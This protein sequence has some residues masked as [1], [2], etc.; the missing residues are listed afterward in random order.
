MADRSARQVRCAIY[1]RKSVARDLDGEQNSL[2]VQRDICSAYVRTQRHRAWTEMP[3]RYDD[4][5]Y[6]GGSLI[7]PALQQLIADV[8]E[9]L[10]DVIVIYKLD[11]LTRSLA[12]FIRLI[13]VF[14]ANGVTFVSVT[15]SF[16]TQDTM[17]RL[18]LNVLL[19]FAQFEREMIADRVRDKM[20]Q[21]KRAGRWT[22]GAPPYGYD[23]IDKR[24]VVNEVEA[25]QVR[26][27]F[28][29]YL[30][31]ESA[32]ALTEELRAGGL[33]A[34]SWVT[35]QGT[36]CGGGIATRG[37]IYG[38]LGSPV[39]I[40]EFHLRGEVFAGQHEPIVERAL[41][42]RVQAVREVR[43]LKRPPRRPYENLLL[44][45]AFDDVGRRMR[46]ETMKPEYGYRYYIS[47]K[48]H[49]ATKRGLKSL[50][51]GG[52]D[53]E[54]LVQAGICSF[55]RNRFALSTAVH[56]LGHRDHRTDMLI[57]RGPIV[58]NLVDRWDRRRLRHAWEAL[59]ARIELSREKVR[60]ILRCDQVVALLEW[61]GQGLFRDRSIAAAD[62]YAV[63]TLELDAMAVRQERRFHLAVDP[64]PARSGKPKRSL[65]DLMRMARA[66]Q[67]A[68]YE[69]RDKSWEEIAR[70]FNRRPGFV[71][72]VLRLNYLAPDI[73]AAI[74][75]GR[76]PPTLDRKTLVFA[77]LPM[78]WSQQRALL[79][80][81][82]QH[83][84]L[85]GDYYY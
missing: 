79:G 30:E 37:L 16:D 33:R 6:S 29:R 32:N 8:E 59:I 38:L 22:G 11:R 61:P 63:H 49:R 44:G 15:Q 72:R 28:E 68:V 43:R 82:S 81:P 20:A 58:A 10:V 74:M 85:P 71:A 3:V 35:R 69:N 39:Y 48:N 70:R 73:I 64:K 4:G 75:D 62:A 7:R 51:A 24:L 56:A 31:V 45:L 83:D 34:K 12:D 46:M 23:L 26:A 78:D 21:M 9:G 60:V 80:F 77:S 40:G 41:W 55:F 25:A 5:G 19:T 76:H 50:R 57:D 52:D 14:E 42:E 36:V 67:E 66:I 27:I 2:E 54:Q 18:V 17:G 84:P 1:T 65:V 47:D 13:D 53:F